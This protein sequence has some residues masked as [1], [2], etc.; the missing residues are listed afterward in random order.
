M[1]CLNEAS[2]GSDGAAQVFQLAETDI[3]DHLL[4]CC[5]EEVEVAPAL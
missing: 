1:S 2:E 3:A 5:A 4:Y